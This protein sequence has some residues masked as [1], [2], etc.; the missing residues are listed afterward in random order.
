MSGSYCYLL[1]RGKGRDNRALLET[2]Q[3][4]VIPQW[5]QIDISVWG[6][7]YGLFGIASNELIV[8][9]VTSN[10]LP[11]SAFTKPLLGIAKIRRL[12]QL[13][14]TVR[15]VTTA[16]CEKSG[17]YVFRTFHIF[18]DDVNE[19]TRLSDEAWKTFENTDDY[20][21]QPQG[22]FCQH[23]R[24]K[25][26]GKMLLVTWYDGLQSWQTSRQPNA[27]ARQNFQLRHAMLRR[28]DAI[29]TRLHVATTGNE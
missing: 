4:Q 19:I 17:L 26:K 18:N 21:A 24:T 5:Q 25:R 8:M 29:A 12:E 13:D 9:A 22:L 16:P 14:A 23:E 6:I 27:D 3:T 10:E 20:H 1:L 15:P 11:L 2:L 28:T 7:F